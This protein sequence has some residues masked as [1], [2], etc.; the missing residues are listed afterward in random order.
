MDRILTEHLTT[1]DHDF[2]RMYK[3]QAFCRPH[4]I[5]SMSPLEVLNPI[6]LTHIQRFVKHQQELINFQKEQNLPFYGEIIQGTLDY[7]LE[8]LI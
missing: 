5:N 8:H 2:H 3:T 7:A 4:E 1:E 6:R